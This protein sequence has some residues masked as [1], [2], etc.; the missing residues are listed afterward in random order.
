MSQNIPKQRLPASQESIPIMGD[1]HTNTLNHASG[2]HFILVGK[3]PHQGDHV[4]RPL[5]SR[6]MSFQLCF[7]A[8]VSN[9]LLVD[10]DDGF[11]DIHAGL[12]TKPLLEVR[13]MSP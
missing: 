2:V 10:A 6:I 3:L 7:H 9:D 4:F 5:S 1:H 12:F 11:K 8:F 13:Y